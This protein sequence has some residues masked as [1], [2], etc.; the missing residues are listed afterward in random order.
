MFNESNSVKIGLT[1]WPLEVSQIWGHKQ[2][3]VAKVI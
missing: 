3:Q 1:V 2:K